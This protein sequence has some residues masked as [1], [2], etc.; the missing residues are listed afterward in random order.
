MATSGS[1]HF[2]VALVCAAAVRAEYVSEYKVMPGHDVFNDYALPLP[3]SYLSD[4]VRN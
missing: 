3:S 1:W 2:A 4:I